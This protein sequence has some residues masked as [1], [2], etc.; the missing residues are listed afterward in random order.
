MIIIK[1]LNRSSFKL[2]VTI[3]CIIIA[4]FEWLYKP[5]CL[6]K[7]RKKRNYLKEN[8]P[9]L[10][11]IHEEKVSKNG[12]IKHICFSFTLEGENYDIGYQ[13]QPNGEKQIYMI[14]GS[15]KYSNLIWDK[16]INQEL[17]KHFYRTRRIPL[18]YKGYSEK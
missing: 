17:Y 6:Y 16:K 8:L 12:D 18:L 5:I 9:K 14:S 15:L 2:L 10:V 11:T 1:K 3:F 13:V 4:I 7:T